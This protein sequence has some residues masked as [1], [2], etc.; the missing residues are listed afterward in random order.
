MSPI[1][2]TQQ[3]II[4][5][6]EF[7]KLLMLGSGGELEVLAPVTDDERRDLETHMRGTFTPGLIFQVKSTTYIDHR[8]K[9]RRLSIHFPVAKDRLI[10][11]PLFWYF[12]GLLDLDAMAYADPVFPLPSEEVHQH[13]NPQL[14]G[15]TWSF[16][17]DPSLEADAEDHWR[18]FQHSTKQV[19]RYLLEVLR[20]RQHAAAAPLLPSGSALELPPGAIWVR[21]K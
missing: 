8:F 21:P 14:K 18:K 5:E 11:H 4:A 15:D 2:T 20:T 19:G 12:F 10:S 6:H 13:A 16:N 9:A 7:M 3:G 17:F 1:S